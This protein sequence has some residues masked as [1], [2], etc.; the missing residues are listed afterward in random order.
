MPIAEGGRWS[1]AERIVSPGVFTRENDLS[2][3]PQGISNIG[4][5]IVGPFPKGPAF[6]PMLIENQADL[7]SMFGISDGTFYG[8]YTAREYLKNQGQVTIVRVG[9]LGGYTQLDP[10]VLYATPVT[11]ARAFLNISLLTHR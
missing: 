6:C 11:T 1:P 2:F 5:A 8:P 4:G 9:A 3:L 7:D 10:L